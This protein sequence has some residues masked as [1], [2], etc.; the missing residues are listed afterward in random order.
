MLCDL[1]IVEYFSLRAIVNVICPQESRLLS[2]SI[3]YSLSF[4]IFLRIEILF[5]ASNRFLSDTKLQIESPLL[6]SGSSSASSLRYS[7]PCRV[8]FSGTSCSRFTNPIFS[9]ILESEISFNFCFPIKISP[10]LTS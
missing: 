8:K 1:L 10:L 2:L 3:M 4:P 6:H 7:L 9:L 5:I